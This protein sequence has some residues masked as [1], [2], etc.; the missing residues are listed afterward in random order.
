MK[1]LFRIIFLQFLLQQQKF[2]KTLEDMSQEM[3]LLKQHR[4]GLQVELQNIEPEEKTEYD[5]PSR[6]ILKTVP[7]YPPMNL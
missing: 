4:S 7:L 6:L 2:E 3:Q 5:Y 1:D